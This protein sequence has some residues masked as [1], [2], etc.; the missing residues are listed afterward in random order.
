[1]RRAI[2]PSNIAK[3]FQ[4]DGHEWKVYDVEAEADAER[5]HAIVAKDELFRRRDFTTADLDLSATWP[6]K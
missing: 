4:L 3:T 2:L 6:R 5:I 1:M